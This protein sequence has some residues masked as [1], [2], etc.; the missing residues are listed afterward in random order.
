LGYL[1]R[2]VARFLRIRLQNSEKLRYRISQE[3]HDEP[4]KCLIF[5]SYYDP[6]RGVIVYFRV[7]SG[8]INKGDQIRF[9]NTGKKFNCDEI[10]VL[11]PGQQPV[12]YLES[13]EVGYMVAGIKTVA[14]ARVGDTI[15]HEQES[16]RAP[17]ALPGYAEANPMVWCGM[18]PSD[19]ADYD[20]LR[21]SLQK[22]KL[23]DAA[24]QFE[25]ENS[26]A[27]GFGFR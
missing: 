13:G 17:E 9:M 16:R 8:R 15:T 11:S 6:Y 21:D 20:A 7:V 10:G 19:A 2:D 5:D 3:R 26:L 22:L 27:M 12:D 25:P 18:F 24:L 4:L 14:D 1:W 23:N